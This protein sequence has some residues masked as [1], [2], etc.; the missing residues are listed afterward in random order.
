LASAALCRRP[1]AEQEVLQYRASRVVSGWPQLAQRR[2]TAVV[3]AAFS[4]LVS[5]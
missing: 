1:F 3:T 5:V 4:L 2:D